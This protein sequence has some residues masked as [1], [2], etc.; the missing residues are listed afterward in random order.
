ME[1]TPEQQAQLRQAQAAGEQRAALSFTPRQK[2]QWEAA[3]QQELAGREENLDR[4]RK[5]QAAA[6]AGGVPGDLRRAITSSRRP[7]QELADE[8]GVDCAL[9]FRLSGRRRGIVLRRLGPASGSPRSPLRCGK[10]RDE[11]PLS[12]VART[13]LKEGCPMRIPYVIDNDRHKLADVLNQV[14]ETHRDLAMDV[15]SAFFNIRGYGLLAREAAGPWKP[16]AVAGGRAALGRRPGP[17]AAPGRFA[18]R[19]SRR[20][21][22]PA[23]PAG[24]AGR[25]RGL[26][27][28]PAA[29]SRPGAALR[30]RLPARQVLPV[31][32]RSQ[33]RPPVRSVPAGAG[34]RGLVQFHRAGAFHEPRVEPRS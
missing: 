34:H 32:W 23:V 18:G 2:A 13:P 28:L 20:F 7:V 14:L 6:E 29:G 31:L 21:G 1:L 5:I 11:S 10:F 12:R 19:P 30:P 15:A 17:Q 25:G 22:N 16:A 26:D 8:I 9:G 3:V 24:N 33:G 4:L 27:P